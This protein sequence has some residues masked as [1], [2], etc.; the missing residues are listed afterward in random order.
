MFS[1]FSSWLQQ[2][3]EATNSLLS[4]AGFGLQSSTQ[5][6]A[7]TTAAD[8]TDLLPV[9]AWE[10][11]PA[12]WTDSPG[13]WRALVLGLL[14]N[15]NTYLI[16][17]VRLVEAEPTKAALLTAPLAQLSLP[18]VPGPF[19][20]DTAPNTKAIDSYEKRDELRYALVPRLVS[21]ENFWANS[22]WRV[23]ALRSTSSAP[24]AIAL[25]RVLNTEP[26]EPPTDA[27]APRLRN[28][29]NYENTEAL[30]K[31]E[32]L[33]ATLREAEAWAATKRDTIS[34]ELKSCR[35]NLQLLR[36]LMAGATTS[37]E[38]VESVRDSC[39]Y[40]KAKLASHISDLDQVD[41]AQLMASPD[42]QAPEGAVYTELLET[43]QDVQQI[44]REYEQW[45]Q[46]QSSKAV[47][48]REVE[49]AAV[50]GIG[51]ASASPEQ[52]APIASTGHDPASPN[53]VSERSPEYYGGRAAIEGDDTAF[54]A[55][56]P[57]DDDDDDDV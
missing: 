22:V 5:D 17:P 41:S 53:S 29:G 19:D 48:A 30:D 50:A 43:N 54:E 4:K 36:N 12:T 2:G 24:T 25:L 28:V 37:V 35:S 51:V 13:Q 47:S 42:L 14:S 49:T 10:H 40:H 38:L 21:E 34:A 8:R 7:A 33:L 11:P 18:P 6:T 52:Q 45:K 3:E 20:R 44:L 27:E 16:P 46:S 9:P 57:W 26:S 1:T 55:Q 56:L 32:R 15:E 39:A 31:I 23:K